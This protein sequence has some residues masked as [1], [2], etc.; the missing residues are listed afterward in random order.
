MI[1][2]FVIDTSTSLGFWLVFAIIRIYYIVGYFGQ[3]LDIFIIAERI[4]LFLGNNRVKSKIMYKVCTAVIILSVI[5]SV[6][7]SLVVVDSIA[8]INSL[9]SCKRLT[10][11]ENM[12]FHKNELFVFFGFFFISLRFLSTFIP[13]LVLNIILLKC[14]K[15]YHNIKQR[16]SST[17]DGR[18]KKSERNNSFIAILLCMISSLLSIS[19]FLLGVKY[20]K[21]LTKFVSFSQS[22][23]YTLQYEILIGIRHSINFFVFYFLS[24]KFK[25]TVNKSF[26][27][28]VLCVYIFRNKKHEV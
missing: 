24:K 14:I 18:I 23:Q 8:Y 17:K 21:N 11:Y 16:L 15:R 28:N 3:L 1:S 22:Y 10:K 5:V 12:N 13:D 20:F 2:I 4:Q 26:F 7:E 19:L 9:L 27:I 6:F 25:K